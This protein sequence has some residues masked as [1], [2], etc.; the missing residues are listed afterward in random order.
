LRVFPLVT[1]IVTVAHARSSAVLLVVRAGRRLSSSPDQHAS[2]NLRVMLRY[3]RLIDQLN[4]HP[5]NALKI[6]GKESR[7]MR[8]LSGVTS[9]EGLL[10]EVTESESK[11][12]TRPSDK[13]SISDL[14]K[15]ITVQDKDPLR[16]AFL[17]GNYTFP[18]YEATKLKT[19]IDQNI[20]QLLTDENAALEVN[21]HFVAKL[22]TTPISQLTSDDF[23]PIFNYWSQIHPNI[24][25]LITWY[26]H[27]VG[28]GIRVSERMHQNILHI[29]CKPSNGTPSEVLEYLTALADSGEISTNIYH[30]VLLVQMQD[31]GPVRNTI[32]H[33]RQYKVKPDAAVGTLMLRWAV[34]QR[35]EDK[36]NEWTKELSRL[37][38]GLTVAHYIEWMRYSY[39]QHDPKSVMRYAQ[40]IRDGGL[41]ITHEVLC[42]VLRYNVDMDILE[43][44]KSVIRNDLVCKE[45]FEIVL[46]C[47]VQ[48]SDSH[49]LSLWEHIY[50]TNYKL[51]LQSKQIQAMNPNVLM[52][53]VRF[54]C[55]TGMKKEIA[56]GETQ[57]IKWLEELRTEYASLPLNIWTTMVRCVALEMDSYHGAIL[58]YENWTTANHP[59]DHY[60]IMLEV[61]LD[62]HLRAKNE[63]KFIEVLDDMFTRGIELSESSQYS[64]HCFRAITKDEE[65]IQYI[66]SAVPPEKFKFGMGSP[67]NFFTEENVEDVSLKMSSRS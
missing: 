18:P 21:C 40:L 14:L 30:T 67:P 31:G 24:N 29:F 49:Q 9:E 48:R 51:R 32:S 61:M 27:L 50:N 56:E 45:T 66:D 36:L 46:E 37:P 1:V 25:E 26:H 28:R 39:L 59:N 38:G 4:R 63:K 60:K 42:A 55:R 13:T 47:I 7:C 57:A 65:F 20:S 2:L 35:D 11:W 12:W 64:L 15:P 3:R 5:F 62:L 53:F 34:D 33:M 8:S 10:S 17:R 52:S 58:L 44:F 22:L 54:L 6:G 19:D 16:L 43:W 23:E 41:P